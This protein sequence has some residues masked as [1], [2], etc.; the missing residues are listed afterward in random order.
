MVVL[1]A[2]RTP[3]TDRDR[4]RRNVKR[5]RAYPRTRDRPMSLALGASDAFKLRS[6]GLGQFDA[7][8][9]LDLGRA[10]PACPNVHWAYSVC[11]LW[12]T[13][14]PAAISVYGVRRRNGNSAAGMLPGTW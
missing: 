13:T 12:T 7:N 10:G 9:R 14:T 11:W 6:L 5:R 3:T 1:S 4:L 2:P 8:R